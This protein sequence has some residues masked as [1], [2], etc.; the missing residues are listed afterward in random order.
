VHAGRQRVLEQLPGGRVRV[1]VKSVLCR[2]LVGDHSP[3]M[4]SSDGRSATPTRNYAS[5]A[6][7]KPHAV[8]SSAARGRQLDDATAGI[9]RQH[10]ETHG[11]VAPIRCADIGESAGLAVH[12]RGHDPVAPRPGSPSHVPRVASSPRPRP[13]RRASTP[14]RHTHD[15]VGRE[16]RHEVVEVAALPRLHEALDDLGLI[17]RERRRRGRFGVPTRDRGAPPLQR[18]VDRGLGGL[19]D[20]GDL[21]DAPV[22]HIV[23]DSAR[24]AGAAAALHDAH[25]RE[26]DPLAQPHSLLGTGHRRN[27]ASGYGSS[28]RMS[29]R[30]AV[31]GGPGAVD[32][33]TSWGSTRAR[34]PL[35]HV[36]A[37]VRDDPVHPRAEARARLVGRERSPRLELRVLQRIVGVVE[38]RRARG[39]RTRAARDRAVRSAHE[40]R[41]RR[42]RGRPHQGSKSRGERGEREPLENSSLMDR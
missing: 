15:R 32:G 38:I 35:E 3:S 27:S 17:R 7:G 41:A 1:A 10:G 31:V 2:R 30:G 39:R 28:H 23:E 9:E 14:W 6:G 42:R 20:A 12:R 40:T 16:Q 4:I 29:E 22:E 5:R 33:P 18:A 26:P 36:E 25:E 8:N 11:V 34:A 13:C 21:G 37:G 19:E 24:R